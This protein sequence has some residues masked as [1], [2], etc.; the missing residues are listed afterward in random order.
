M[1]VFSRLATSPA[2]TKHLSRGAAS[3][4]AAGAL[5]SV[6][7]AAQAEEPRYNQISLRAE[8]SQDVPRDRMQVTLYTEQQGNDPAKLAADITKALNEGVEAARKVNGVEISQGGR[9]SFPLYDDKRQTITAW[10]ERGELHLQSSDFASLSRLTAD[11]LGT[12]KMGGMTFTVADET[13]KKSED[14][15]LKE[16][17]NAFKA[18]AQ[19]ATDALGGS[20]YKLVNLNLITNNATGPMPMMRMK[21]MAYAESAPSQDIE[22]GTSAVSITADGVIEVQ[23]P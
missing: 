1:P 18:R 20:G 8:V 15:L 12:L 11:L 5:V 14:A 3:I 13:R 10:R 19:L 23:T 2:L 17:V 4:M 22:A 7:H 21:T 9:N 6:S 16:A